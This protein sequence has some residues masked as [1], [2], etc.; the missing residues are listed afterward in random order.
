MPL[1]H[2]V[3]AIAHDRRAVDIGRDV[4]AE[5][6]VEKIVLG[7][8]GKILAAAYDVGNA[9]EMVVD[10]ICKVIRGKTVGF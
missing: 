5:G 2:L 1:G 7:R 4:P 3:L 10:D 8:R 9:H 6:F